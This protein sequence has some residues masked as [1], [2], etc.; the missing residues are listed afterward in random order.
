VLSQNNSLAKASIQM[1]GSA[2]IKITRATLIQSITHLH[3]HTDFNCMTAYCFF[4]GC[5]L[6]SS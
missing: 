1:L 4:T 3:C 5:T 6:Y 2:G